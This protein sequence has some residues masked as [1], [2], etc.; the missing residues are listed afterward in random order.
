MKK[1]VSY[2]VIVWLVMQSVISVCQTVYNDGV[3][4][5]ITSG[6]DVYL[7]QLGF[8][9]QTNGTDGSVDNDGNINID[10][11]WTNNVAGNN[12][13]VNTDA[14]GSTIFTG[15]S[16]QAIGGSNTTTFESFTALNTTGA[17]AAIT[18]NLN[19]TVNEVL[20]LT[21]GVISTGANTF[22]MAST[23][24]ADLAAYSN[25]SFINGNLQRGIA[26][27]SNTYSFPVG[28]GTATTNYF[29][30]DMLN[31][32]LVTTSSVTASVTAITE[33]AS[34]V[35]NDGDIVAT[36]D[37]TPIIDVHEEAEWT[38]TPDAAPVAGSFGVDLYTANIPGLMDDEFT[39]LRRPTGS[40][41][42][43]Q[44]DSFEATTGKPAAGAP[45]RTVASGRANKTGF[46]GFGNF[47][48]GSGAVPLPIE[49]NSFTAKLIERDVK[50]QWVTQTEINNDYFTIERSRDLINFEEVAVV[51]GAGNSNIEL[52]YETWDRNPYEGTSYYRLRQTDFDGTYSFSQLEKITINDNSS[53]HQP[54][55]EVY[56]NPSN[57]DQFYSK[58][59]GFSKNSEVLIMVMD[60]VG[61]QHYSKIIVTDSNGEAI[62][63]VDPYERLS[64]GT[65]IVTG[66]EDNSLYQKQ[67]IIY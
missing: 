55:F 29:L 12:V 59:T 52:R 41:D 47:A 31:S 26:T 53:V 13:F 35:N 10:G 65:Y 49:L 19:A 25:A 40:N 7:D 66:T 44:W 15:A 11:N 61:K 39:P 22:I 30:L 8:Q 64:P 14:T 67:I 20:T 27:N 37:G 51:D 4:L 23:T 45:G 58:L 6:T 36:E 60:A 9:N 5:F 28:N 54:I 17:G 42:Y 50:L 21:D 43:S 63:A 2:L 46:S 34:P 18:L 48:V 56:P 24:A 32:N 57:G 16:N 62:S 1:S 38:L 33:A 3:D